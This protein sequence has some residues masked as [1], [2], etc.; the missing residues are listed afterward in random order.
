MKQITTTYG[1][2]SGGMTREKPAGGGKAPDFPEELS[3]KGALSH[4]DVGEP[5][6]TVWWKIH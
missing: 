6:V 2:I 5:E 4:G 3:S 1:K